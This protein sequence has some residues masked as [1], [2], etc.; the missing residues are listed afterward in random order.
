MRRSSAYMLAAERRRLRAQLPAL[1]S[2]LGFRSTHPPTPLFPCGEWAIELESHN[3]ELSVHPCI[4]DDGS[5]PWVACCF[6]RQHPEPFNA[7]A[8]GVYLDLAAHF[9][10]NAYTGKCNWHAPERMTAVEALD[11]I[12]SHLL[13]ITTLPIP[14]T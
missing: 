8:P 4:E 2:K 11:A 7:Y 9:G 10:C 3:A 5:A 6:H 14:A 1:L 13:Y 12:R